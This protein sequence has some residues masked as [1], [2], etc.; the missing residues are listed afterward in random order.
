[1][2]NYFSQSDKIK[3]N[4][5]KNT[6]YD[7]KGYRNADSQKMINYGFNF[8]RISAATISGRLFHREYHCMKKSLNFS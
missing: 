6:N 7:K 4:V 8:K 3:K 2:K 1:M 5:P